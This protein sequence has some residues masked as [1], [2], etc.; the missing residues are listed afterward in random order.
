MDLP[1]WLYWEGDKP[2]WI[3]ACHRTIFYHVRDVRLINPASFNALRDRDQEIDLSMLCIAHRADYIRVFLLAKFGGLWID[4]DC[5]VMKSLQPLINLLKDY[6]FI[7]IRERQG[8]L[9]NSFIGAPVNSKIANAYYNIVCETLRSGHPIEWLTIGSHALTSAI[10]STEA[11]WYEIDV[12]YIQPICWS[13]QEA[14]F[15]IRDNEEHNKVFNKQSYCYMLANNTVEVLVKNNPDFYIL[16]EETFFN[17]LLKKS[18]ETRSN[19][20]I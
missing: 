10:N 3:N 2:E 17:F 14:F 18:V 11:N 4:S 20:H 19:F 8:T 5:I 13:N 7:T 6:D 9:S 15:A 16:K 12:S 1:I